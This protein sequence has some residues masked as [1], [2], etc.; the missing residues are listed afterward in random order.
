MNVQLASLSI[1]DRD[2]E[3]FGFKPRAAAH[4]ARFAAHER[5]DSIAGEFTLGLLVKPLHLRHQSFER[6][7]LLAITGEIHLDRRPVGAEIKRVLKFVRQVRERHVL[8]DFEM[9]HQRALQLT[10]ISLHSFR[11]APPWCNR[12]FGNCFCFV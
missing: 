12:A 11:P 4:L 1:F 5:A 2:R 8:I 9:F 6:S 7:L 3:N 10:I